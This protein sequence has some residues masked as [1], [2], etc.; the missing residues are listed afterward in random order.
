[1]SDTPQKEA[2]DPL[3]EYLIKNM[4]QLDQIQYSLRD[5]LI[6]LSQIATKYGLYDAADHIR[7]ELTLP[8]NNL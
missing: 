2:V 8:F 7:H 5:Q 3:L 6:Y 4:D 1:M